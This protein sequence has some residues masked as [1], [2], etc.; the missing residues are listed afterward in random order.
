MQNFNTKYLKIRD[1]VI[2]TDS[3]IPVI[4]GLDKY[5]TDA[6]FI[7]WITSGLRMPED[8]LR[9]IREYARKYE[10]DKKFPKINDCNLT[11]KDYYQDQQIFKWQ[12][13]W[14]KLLNIGIIISPP[15]DAKC[16][17]DYYSNGENKKG[18]IIKASEH[19]NGNC[20]DIGGSTGKPD[21]SDE[22]VIIQRAWDDKKIENWLSWKIERKN[23]CIHIVCKLIEGNNL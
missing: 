5:F 1:N 4:I 3:H 8:Q 10:I 16:L 21:V 15:L 2:I 23:N 12:T 6:K 17:F 13:A 14:S 9:I 22:E 18:K 19:I 11:D 7:A 20:F